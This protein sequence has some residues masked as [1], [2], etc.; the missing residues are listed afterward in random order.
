MSSPSSAFMAPEWLGS[1]KRKRSKAITEYF[2]EES[3]IDLKRRALLDRNVSNDDKKKQSDFSQPSLKDFISSRNRKPRSGPAP[4]K[5][6]PCS[7]EAIIP[8]SFVS[9]GVRKKV[10]PSSAASSS[11]VIKSPANVAHSPV[12]H[13]VG[14]KGSHK[15]NKRFE[16]DREQNTRVSGDKVAR[17][18]R[19]S[20]T[21]PDIEDPSHQLRRTGMKVLKTQLFHKNRSAVYGELDQ[22]KDKENQDPLKTDKMA[23][24]T[25]FLWSNITCDGNRKRDPLSDVT[26]YVCP[27]K[28]NTSPAPTAQEAPTRENTSSKHSLEST[29]KHEVRRNRSDT[30]SKTTGKPR[31]STTPVNLPLPDAKKP[32]VKEVNILDFE[33]SDMDSQQPEELILDTE[34]LLAKLSY[35]EKMSV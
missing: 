10:S 22:E 27:S 20:R 7:K 14:K 6:S 12:E 34:E 5:L 15:E 16:Q 3:K 30:D 29:A 23:G 4:S 8:V 25:R 11:R 31:P 2:T 19:R 33:L 32:P 26:L 24:K 35:C 1:R 17:A 18:H 21:C 9:T 13:S 28:D